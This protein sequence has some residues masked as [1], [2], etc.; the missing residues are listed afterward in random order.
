MP[1]LP[2]LRALLVG[3]LAVVAGTAAAQQYRFPTTAAHY[4]DWYPTAYKDAG[5]QD[6]NC[7]SIYY[8]GHGGSDFGGGSWAG[9]NAGRDVVAAAPG[10]VE[11][12]EDG[13]P[14]D[15]SSAD[16]PG[17]GG[18]G[19]HVVVLHPDGR[20]TYYAHLKTWSIPVSVGDAV[21]CGELL[22]QMGS[23]GYSTGPHLHFEVRVGG[24]SG[25][26]YSGTRTDPFAGPC[27]P[28]PSTHWTSQG[29]HGALPGLTCDGQ[30]PCVV[31]GTLSCGDSISA[32][33]SGAGSTSTAITYSCTTF[34]YTGPERAWALDVAPGTDVTVTM[35][36]LSAD[37]DLFVSEGATCAPEQCVG[38]STSSNTSQ[39]TVSFTSS[40]SGS[41]V[42]IADGWDGATSD[43][44]MTVTCTGGPSDD[45]DAAD[46]D[47]AVDDDDAANDD[48]AV[49]DDDAA[50][51][52]DAVDDDD[53]ASGSG[54]PPMGIRRSLTDE[55]SGCR[56]S[57][58]P[59]GSPLAAL[60]LVLALRRRRRD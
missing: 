56:A 10:T 5:G 31:D 41:Y 29:S 55:G 45:D 13:W 58:S 54:P 20:R 47:D 6:W 59:T 17:G 4:G 27:S 43:L 35:G 34:F 36:G 38:G 24:S 60:L 57:Q 12:T 3:G 37:L 23:S 2:L 7:G 49:D 19:N 39:E 22:G 16:C 11:V 53:S 32:S 15:C 46:D 14:D 9:M 48:D 26:P 42:V 18:F 1:A 28:T 33:N 52:D 44:T 30:A 25:Q 51:D 50:N 21:A 8:S 40:G